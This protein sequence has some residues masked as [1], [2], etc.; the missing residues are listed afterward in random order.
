MGFS[1]PTNPLLLLGQVANQDSSVLARNAQRRAMEQN[2]AEQKAMFPLHNQL[3]NQQIAYQKQMANFSKAKAQ[4]L[5]F[6]RQLAMQYGGQLQS[7]KTQPSQ[8]PLLSPTDSLTNSVNQRIPQFNQQSP[9]NLL[10][11][12]NQPN[13]VPT[14][15]GLMSSQQLPSQGFNSLFNLNAARSY[16][17]MK[18]ITPNL[19]YTMQRQGIKDFESQPLDIQD[20]QYELGRRLGLSAVQVRNLSNKGSSVQDYAKQQGINL[21]DKSPAYLPT[22]ATKSLAQKQKVATAAI[23]LMSPSMTRYEAYGLPGTV[24]G[25]SPAQ[26]GSGLLAWFNKNPTKIEGAARLASIPVIK[27]EQAILRQQGF[28]GNRSARLLEAI[29]KASGD[30]KTLWAG[31]PPAVIKK[32]KY[33][34]NK[35]QDM[36][37]D[38]SDLNLRNPGWSRDQI[39]N[40]L[41]KKYSKGP[42]PL[43]LDDKGWA[44]VV[45]DSKPSMSTMKNQSESSMPKFQ[46]KED[47][48]KWYKNLSDQQKKHHFGG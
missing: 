24:E 25:Y 31:L 39:V 5:E 9:T 33:Y 20:H 22:T 48:E 45:G 11:S 13:S 28:T 6:K 30:E 42:D 47:A 23:D 4:Q 14:Q 16:A 2:L 46:S 18:P 36:T 12:Q 32:A 29:K 17:G 38:A 37:N 7:N 15:N 3:L 8:N 40:R 19:Q 21:D 44:T 26:I 35:Y 43:L 1:P 10:L 41:R 27:T 34:V